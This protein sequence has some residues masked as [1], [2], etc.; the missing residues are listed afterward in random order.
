M[1]RPARARPLIE[2]AALALFSRLGVEL[3]TTSAIAAEA[4]V[5]EAAIY[6]HFDSKE[7]LAREIFARHYKALAAELTDTAQGHHGLPARLHAMI[8]HVCALF[9]A[10]PARLRFLLLTQHQSLPVLDEDGNTPVDSVRAEIVRAIDQGEIP[11]QDPDLATALVFGLV[12]QP[13]TFH[14]YGRLTGPLSAR[15]ERL[16]AAAL[17]VLSDA[18]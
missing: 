6:R 2:H 7:A 1:P 5:S 4:G 3:A 11:S 16:T 17:G 15:A 12:L 9:D 18:G 10:D 8:A 13:A 14:A